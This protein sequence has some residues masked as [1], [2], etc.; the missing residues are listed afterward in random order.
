MSTTHADIRNSAWPWK[1]TLSVCRD[2][3]LGTAR[4]WTLLGLCYLLT[5]VSAVVDG[6]SW[7]LL[8]NMFSSRVGMAGAETDMALLQPLLRSPLLAQPDAMMELVAALFLSRAALT[9]LTTSLDAMLAAELRRRLQEEGLSRVITGRWEQLRHLHVGQLVGTLT[10]EAAVFSKFVMSAARAGFSLITFLMLGGMALAVAP[11]LTGIGLLVALPAWFVLKSLYSRQ[12]L[13]SG[14][15]TLARQGFAADITER[16]SGLYQIKA[17]GDT[18]PH[19]RAGTRRQEA[20]TNTEVSIGHYTGLIAAFNPLLFP[21][22]M[23]AYYLWTRG[24]GH[25]LTGELHVMGSVGVLGYRAVSQLNGLVAAVGNLTRLAGCVAPLHRLCALLPEPPREPLPEPLRGIRL[26]GLG[27]TY[28]KRAVLHDLDE[29]LEPGRIILVSGP[30][31]CGKTTLANLIAGLLE[32][33]EGSVHY[34][35]RSGRSYSARAYRAR[36]GYVT[37]DIHLFRGT[38]RFNLDP[39]EGL[40]EADLRR[41]LEQAGAA[42][43]V[44]RMGGLDAEVAEAGRSLSGGEK[45]RLAIAATLAQGADC[46]ILDEVTNGLDGASRDALLETVAAISRGV[47]VVAI[48][49]DL[50]AFSA[51]DPRVIRLDAA[52]PHRDPVP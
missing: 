1:E 36:I 50:A 15:L 43:F 8:V 46:L 28:K 19:L 11:G 3:Q 24:H 49:H 31:G 47:L 52:H 27:Y 14:D 2:F 23:A 17:F 45:R 7:V 26:E 33:S 48:S 40:P 10:E 39:R 51:V 20:Y 37:Q 44:E 32:P 30:S 38:V 18:S 29:T 13:L 25:T 12:A 42:A 41:S 34:A 16:L 6:L 22:L 35:G 4:A 21:I 9:A 5:P